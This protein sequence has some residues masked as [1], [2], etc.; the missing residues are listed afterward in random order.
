MDFYGFFDCL[1]FQGFWQKAHGARVRGVKGIILFPRNVHDRNGVVLVGVA[2]TK[3]RLDAVDFIFGKLNI[4]EYQV[5][6]HPPSIVRHNTS[7]ES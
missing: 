7:A 6:F 4:K 5:E 2:D 3:Y 1:R